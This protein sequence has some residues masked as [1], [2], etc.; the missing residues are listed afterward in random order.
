[1]NKLFFAVVLSFVLSGIGFAEQVCYHH[2]SPAFEFDLCF[3]PAL[4]SSS[5]TKTWY[6]VFDIP[7]VGALNQPISYS[8]DVYSIAL[9]GPLRLIIFDDSGPKYLIEYMGHYYSVNPNP[10]AITV[11]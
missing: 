5:G 8:F 9:Q 10:L 7:Q 3:D 11:K 6:R 2:N 1:M 4:G